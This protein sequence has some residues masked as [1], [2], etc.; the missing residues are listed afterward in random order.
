MKI[1][2][3]DYNR[4]MS[5]L[6]T[7]SLDTKMPEVAAYLN[8]VLSTAVVLAPERIPAQ[9]IT[10]NSRVLLKDTSGD[11]SAEL[12]LTYPHEADHS[13]GKVSIFSPIGAALLGKQVGE[14]VSWETPKGKRWFEIVQVTYQPE[15]VG[16]YA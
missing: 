15:A 12:T 4:L 7:T 13:K 3:H 9:V 6:E 5:L 16:Q 11:R 8:D 2:I 1:T 10:M 14:R